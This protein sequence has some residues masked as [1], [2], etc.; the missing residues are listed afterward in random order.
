MCDFFPFYPSLLHLFLIRD[1]PPFFFLFN[2]SINFICLFTFNSIITNQSLT[3]VPF[4]EGGKKSVIR[5]RP[6]EIGLIFFFPIL[7]LPFTF[8]SHTWL[9]F[10][11]FFF[12][13]KLI[14]IFFNLL[15]WVGFFLYKV[16]RSKLI[17]WVIDA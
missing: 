1:P 2:T 8:I 6:M 16:Y 9:P 17:Q 4:P 13:K 15:G 11:S 10:N 5:E 12:N 3:L 7:P 14:Y